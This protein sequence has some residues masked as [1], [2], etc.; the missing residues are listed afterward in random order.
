ML[1]FLLP[2]LGAALSSSNNK[3]PME[4]FDFKDIPE[5]PLTESHFLA[6]FLYMMFMLGLLIGAVLF[7]TW[8]LKRMVNTRL[9]QLN[10][11]SN[12]K[13]IEKRTL[14]PKSSL[15]LLEIDGK[16]IILAESPTQIIQLRIPS[17]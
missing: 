15:Y 7:A 14:S 8:F 12:I 9:T 17:D 13:V 10:E 4:P 5:E 2:L 1:T 11:S 6:E 3:A 16:E